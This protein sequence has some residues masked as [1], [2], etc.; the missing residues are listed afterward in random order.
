M[1]RVVYRA[2]ARGTPVAS[3]SRGMVAFDLDPRNASDDARLRRRCAH[4]VDAAA[5]WLNSYTTEKTIIAVHDTFGRW[6][7][8]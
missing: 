2:R 1:R 5:K 7:L 6:P 8:R 3:V 4:D